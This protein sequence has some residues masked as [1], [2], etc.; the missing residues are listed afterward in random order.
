MNLLHTAPLPA[1]QHVASS[2]WE[3][4]HDALVPST[5]QRQ[6]QPT[7]AQADPYPSP[8]THPGLQQGAVPL[9]YPD[10]AAAVAPAPRRCPGRAAAA[11]ANKQ[12]VA[13]AQACQLGLAVL[14]EAH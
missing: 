9:Q 11:A 3:H 8:P 1:V 12:P 4:W 14:E 2:A 13:A 5:K 10:Q 7:N 6:P